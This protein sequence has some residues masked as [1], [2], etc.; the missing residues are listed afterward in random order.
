MGMRA[1]LSDPIR[2]GFAVGRVRV[3]ETRLLG[4]PTFERLLDAP[5]FAEQRRVLSETHVGRYLEGAQ[6]SADVERG[7]A[8]SLADLYKEFLE[9][10]DLPESVVSFF[11]LPHDFGNVV[12]V[13]KARLLGIEP[14]GLLSPLGSVALEALSGDLGELPAGLGPFAASVLASDPPPTTA[15]LETL[16]DRALYASLTEAALSS[17]VPFLARLATMRIDLA[18][19]KALLRAGSFGLSPAEALERVIPGGDPGLAALAADVRLPLG[20]LAAR[21][22]ARPTLTGATAA[23]LADQD[24]LDVVLDDLAASELADARRVPYGPAPVIAYVLARE[25]EA[26]ALRSLLLGKL[27]SVDPAVLRARLRRSFR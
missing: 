26:L 19:A 15:G 7:L 14:E 2:Y 20:D 8:A 22:A 6:T 17:R 11:R 23:E 18:N 27:A 25:G 9:A 1:A 4:R 21:I 24:G 10:S 12:S 16:A 13:L 5:T 3:L